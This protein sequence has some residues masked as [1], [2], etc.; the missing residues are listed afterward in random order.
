MIFWRFFCVPEPPHSE[1]GF[2][3]I[4]PWPPQEGQGDAIEKKPALWRICPAPLQ[5]G[6]TF[7]PAPLAAPEPLHEGQASFLE[8]CISTLVP[9]TASLNGISIS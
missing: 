8:Y 2:S 3:M 4:S 9:K 7:L 1:H 5:V 6:Q